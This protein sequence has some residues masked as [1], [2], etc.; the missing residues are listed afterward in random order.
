VAGMLR[1]WD[2]REAGAMERGH[3]K[4]ARAAGAVTGEDATGAVGAV[5][6]R[7][8]ADEQQARAGIAEARHRSSP[9]GLVLERAPLLARDARAAGAQAR[10]AI[11]RDDLRADRVEP[12]RDSPAR[13]GHGILPA[14]ATHQ[15]VASPDATRVGPD[16]RRV[17]LALERLR[18]LGHVRRWTVHAVL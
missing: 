5:R 18:E 9:V 12:R 16:H 6:G 8:E 13:A 2:V 10:A 7:R 17:R 3:Q 4:V 11:A 14:P 15:S 1:G